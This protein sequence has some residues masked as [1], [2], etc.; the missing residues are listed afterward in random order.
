MVHWRMLEKDWTVRVTAEFLWVP[1]WGLEELEVQLEIL[2]GEVGISARG[3]QYLS[4]LTDIV[5]KIK[6]GMTK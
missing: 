4:L 2:R 6:S 1:K 3:G 5:E